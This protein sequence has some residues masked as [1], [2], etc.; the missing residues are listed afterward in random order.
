LIATFTPTEELVAGEALF[1]VFMIEIG[2]KYEC[3]A[4]RLL[5][6]VKT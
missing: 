2:N 4:V 6:V 3:A 5:I 1:K